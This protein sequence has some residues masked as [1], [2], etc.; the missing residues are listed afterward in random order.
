[1]ASDCHR[2]LAPRRT[3]QKEGGFYVFALGNFCVGVFPPPPPPRPRPRTLAPSTGAYSK[4]GT[5]A[6]EEEVLADHDDDARYV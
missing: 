6:P 2:R 5:G 3:N 4:C 1:M